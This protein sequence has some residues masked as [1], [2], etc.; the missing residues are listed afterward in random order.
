[1][2]MNCEG[3]TITARGV[4]RGH[5]L[6]AL[7]PKFYPSG[8]YSME[9]AAQEAFTACF[10]AMAEQK[11]IG[12]FETVGVDFTINTELSL[13][14]QL[15]AAP[16]VVHSFVIEDRKEVGK[17]HNIDIVTFNYKKF[18]LLDVESGKQ[19]GEMLSVRQVFAIINN[20]AIVEL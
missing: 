9:E 14:E 19:L 6:L 2:S 3:Y 7:R 13:H 20:P 5:K 10:K 16:T 11:P 8:A 1:M 4:R 15:E 18:W 12:L 17:L